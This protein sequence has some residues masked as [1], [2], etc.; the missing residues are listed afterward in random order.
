MQKIRA[1]TWP[2]NVR[3]LENTLERGVLFCKGREITE[4]DVEVGNGNQVPISWKQQKEQ[5][6]AEV[7]RNFLQTSLQQFQG[8]IKKIAG[9]MEI[10][11]RAVYNKLSKYRINPDDYRK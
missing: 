11:P 4:L 1:Y 9:C 8:D 7:E 2:G 3:E 6:I 5:A 10:T